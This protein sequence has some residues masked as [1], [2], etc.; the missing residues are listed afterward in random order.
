MKKIDQVFI[1]HGTHLSLT[2]PTSTPPFLILVLI[3]EWKE[4]KVGGTY[5]IGGSGCERLKL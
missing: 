2:N 3:Y 5:W 4:R 1:S